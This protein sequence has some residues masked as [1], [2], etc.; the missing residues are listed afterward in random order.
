MLSLKRDFEHQTFK[1]CWDWATVRI[2]EVGLSAFCIMV[3]SRVCGDQG[4]ECRGLNENG[5]YRLMFECLVPS[6]WNCLGRIGRCGLR[7]RGVSLGVGF[8]DSKDWCHSQ[9]VLC[10]VLVVQDV[11]PQPLLH[12]PAACY[13]HSVMSSTP[14]KS[15]INAFFYRL[16][17]SWCLITAIEK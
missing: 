5:L 15:Q 16:P 2:C 14:L 12:R 13:L 3:W 9:C 10:P 1:Q 17:W 11:N 7:E 6:W 4:V 8:E